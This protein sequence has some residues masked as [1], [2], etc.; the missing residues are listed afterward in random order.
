MDNTYVSFLESQA[1]RVLKLT[2]KHGLEAE[3]NLFYTLTG[4][5]RY[6]NSQITQNME[7][8]KVSV[9]LR[10]ARGKKIIGGN[11]SDITDIGLTN[12]VESLANSLHHSPEIPFFDGFL[13]T[14]GN[15][16]ISQLD[17]STEQWNIEQRADTIAQVISQAEKKQKNVK[18]AGT[19]SVEEATTLFIAVDGTKHTYNTVNN[20]FKVNAIVEDGEQ[21]GYGQKELYWR[22]KK[23]NFS[24]L[25]NQVVDIAKATVHPKQYN[26][27]E[28]TV[29]LGPQ[30]TSEL[31]TFIQFNLEANAFHEGRSFATDSLGATLFDK[32]FHL[33]D[34]PL[35]PSVSNIALPIDFEGTMR[36]NRVIVDHGAIVFVPYSSFTAS[37]YLQDK[38][39]TTGHSFDQNF[40]LCVSLVQ[41][42][43]I[44]SIDHIIAD[45]NNGLYINEFWYTRFTDPRKGGLTGLTR[46]GVFEIKNGELGDA[47]N[48]FRYTDSF[49][50]IFGPENI[51]GVAKEPV[52]NEMNTTCATAVKKFKFTSKAHSMQAN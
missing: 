34:K 24:E 1:E 10:I 4:T 43:G 26:P 5:S 36:E 12:F 28:Y 6:A 45:I 27:G 23:P 39:L 16:K 41:E 2:T 33:I 48:N 46:N 21:R 20:Y 49:L 19:C 9:N 50:S 3:L 11:T 25:T 47:V 13:K 18:M 30:A 42:Q 37:H 35:D 14:N 51:I 31:L 15:T 29:V 40:A 32:Q 17:M 44:E 52:M 8:T 38:K 7:E 22:R